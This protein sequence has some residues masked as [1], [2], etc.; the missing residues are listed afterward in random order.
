MHVQLSHHG[1]EI[2]YCEIVYLQELCK[3][4]VSHEIIN[5][6]WVHELCAKQ[7]FEGLCAFCLQNSLSI[8][9]RCK[10]IENEM[11][12]DATTSLLARKIV[13]TKADWNLLISNAKK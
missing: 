6:T 12:L 1:S 10:Y 13:E 9:K 4:Y 3:A 2:I 8:P 11:I 5:D 7:V